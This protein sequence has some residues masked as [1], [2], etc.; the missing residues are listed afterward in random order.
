MLQD[1]QIDRVVLK[2][3][4]LENAL[5]KILIKEVV[6]PEVYLEKEGKRIPAV[7][8]LKWGRDF[9]CETFSFTAEGLSEGVKY[10]LYANTGSPEHQ[11]SVNGR[12]VGM[13]DYISN[14]FEPPA[15]THRYLLLENLKNGDKVSLE[16]Y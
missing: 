3:Q 8:G 9:K 14:A 1:R 12:K 4:R 16:A 13:L 7:K 5:E 11:V 10:Y 2:I 15:R 6:R